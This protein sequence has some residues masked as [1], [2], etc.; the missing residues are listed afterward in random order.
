MEIGKYTSG[1]PVA[2]SSDTAVREAVTIMSTRQIGAILVVDD[3]NLV[4]IFTERDL[5]RLIGE[6]SQH[7]LDEPIGEVMTPD[8]VCAEV[9]DDFNSVYNT[10]KG[11]GIRH[12]PV[13]DGKNLV[14]IVSIRDLTHTYQN[15]LES[16]FQEARSRINELE[17]LTGLDN[18]GRVKLL[19][20]E[21]ERYRELSLTDPLTGL[22]NKRYFNGRL[23]EETAR[24]RRYGHPFSLIFCDVDHFK[25]VN[26][27]YGHDYGDQVLRA[28][29]GVLSGHIQ[30]MNVVSRLRKSDIVARYGGEEFV[31][32]LP[33]TQID[34][35]VAAAEHARSA[36]EATELEATGGILKI[37]CS[38]GVAE[39]TSDVPG[40]D[41]LV[42]R[43]DLALYR[44]KENGRNRVE[45]F[46][47]G[48]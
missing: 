23:A 42:K 3:G 16:Q 33:G 12:I 47:L 8:P 28:I 34:G 29:A 25:E 38:F 26:D 32:I 36:I 48:T 46:R 37:T 6:D 41:V 11:R 21:I 22:Y 2:V 27:R 35:A 18:G 31:A 43:A 45:A 5:L 40:S 13:T 24:A 19:M 17:R 10:M 4:G 1:E 44:A 39:M 20:Q 14:G 9:A 7:S 30:E 15:F